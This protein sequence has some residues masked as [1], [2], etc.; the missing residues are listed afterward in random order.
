MLTELL[1]TLAKENASK[2]P[3]MKE[4][5]HKIAFMHEKKKKF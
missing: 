2:E 1:T 5:I 3:R 4:E